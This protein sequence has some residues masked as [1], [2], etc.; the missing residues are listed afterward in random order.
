M[1]RVFRSDAFDEGNSMTNFVEEW[2]ECS[3][4]ECR[5]EYQPADFGDPGICPECELAEEEAAMA[6]ERLS[7]QQA[8]IISEFANAD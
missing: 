5:S 2:R 3:N 8:E 1:S 4:P 6:L 7:E